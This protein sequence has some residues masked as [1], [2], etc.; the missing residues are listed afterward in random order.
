MY[1]YTH[2]YAFALAGVETDQI[3]ATLLIASTP[4]HNN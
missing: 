1:K 2:T 3:P 4:L